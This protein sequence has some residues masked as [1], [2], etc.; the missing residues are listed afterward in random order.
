MIEPS[1]NY[2]NVICL[3]K[4]VRKL[5]GELDAAACDLAT[6]LSKLTPAEKHAYIEEVDRLVQTIRT[7]MKASEVPPGFDSQGSD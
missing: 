2:Q 4:E 1:H 3:L 7:R 6:A 5:E